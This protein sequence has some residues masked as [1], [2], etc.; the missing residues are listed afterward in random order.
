MVFS[1]SNYVI[2]TEFARYDEKNG[3][4]YPVVDDVF[5]ALLW[6]NAVSAQ[7]SASMKSCILDGM[8]RFYKHA[9]PLEIFWPKL[10][11]F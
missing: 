1:V 11:V 10:W 3:R 7:R 9:P 5:A 2:I 6:N 4:G 8:L